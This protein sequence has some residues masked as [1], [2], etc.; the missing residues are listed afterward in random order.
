M[1]TTTILLVVL[2]LLALFSYGLFA[3]ALY[4]GLRWAKYP[5]VRWRVVLLT[6]IAIGVSSVPIR[7]GARMFAGSRHESM[8]VGE[9][10]AFVL[11]TLVTWVLIRAVFHGEWKR[12]IQAW[13]PT[14]ASSVVVAIAVIIIAALVCEAFITS[15]NSLAPTLLGR[16]YLGKCSQCGRSSYG[17]PPLHSISD[18][19]WVE[20]T[21]MICERFHT[22]E[23]KHTDTPIFGADRFLVW[24]FLEPQRWDLVTFRTPWNPEQKFVKRLVGLPGETVYVHDGA[25]WVNGERLEPPAALA[26]LRYASDE[27]AHAENGT[28]DNPA[29]LGDDEYFVLGDFSA[30]SMD[31]RAW[32]EGAPGHNRYAVPQSH[33][34]GVVTHLYWPP[35]RFQIF[36]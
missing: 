34:V 30:Q 1:F 19:D 25:V 22:E 15:G 6:T 10:I 5:N 7:A 29:V 20:P 3:L 32:R 13:L 23:V 4:W 17:T 35:K 26:D 16:H 9:L 33:L 28:K 18:S 36:R 8:L 21:P 2:G 31:S 27:T 24:K 14:L 11:A 12:V